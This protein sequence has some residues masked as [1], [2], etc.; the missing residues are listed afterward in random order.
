MRIDKITIR[1]YKSFNESSELEFTSGFNIIAGQNNTGKTALLETLGLRFN[2]NPHRSLI[3]MPNRDTLVDPSS[4][5]DI[6]VSMS[7]E[8]SASILAAQGPDAQFSF[9]LPRYPTAFSRQIGYLQ[10]DEPNVVRL[11]RWI[12]EQKQQTFT[13]RVAKSA[14]SETWAPP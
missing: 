3:T 14:A 5:V 13:V 6:S 2:G 8:E 12:F 10:N 4:T 11:V 9:A 1:N 7:G